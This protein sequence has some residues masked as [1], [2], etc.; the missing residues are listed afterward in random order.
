LK[1]RV[2]RLLK[3]KYLKGVKLP[4]EIVVLVKGADRTP[5]NSDGVA[6]A[7]GEIIKKTKE[8]FAQTYTWIETI[9]RYQEGTSF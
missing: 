3:S 2:R 4:N 9:S 1:I 8:N 6:N 7:R 5:I